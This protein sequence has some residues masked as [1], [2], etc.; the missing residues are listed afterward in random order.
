MPGFAS[1]AA[2]WGATLGEL[3]RS[4]EALAAFTQALRHRS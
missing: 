3:N 2:N 4:D 1:A